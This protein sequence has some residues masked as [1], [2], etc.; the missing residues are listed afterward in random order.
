VLLE[1]AEPDD[2]LAV[3]ALSLA[4]LPDALLLSA[5]ESVR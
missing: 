3:L 4:V 5:R 1:L 2:A